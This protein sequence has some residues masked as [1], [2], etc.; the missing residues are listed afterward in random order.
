MLSRIGWAPSW[1]R[2]ISA[3]SRRVSVSGDRCTGRRIDVRLRWWRL[4]DCDG[5]LRVDWRRCNHNSRLMMV[6]MRRDGGCSHSGSSGSYKRHARS[7]MMM[8]WA[9][10]V[11]MMMMKRHFCLV[12]LAFCFLLTLEFKY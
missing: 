12:F 5:G 7:V 4:I 1:R 10:V 8:R 11:M 9:M 2:W 6:M 3:S